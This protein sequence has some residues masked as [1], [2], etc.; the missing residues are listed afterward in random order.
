[1]T[2]PTY[3]RLFVKMVRD[4]TRAHLSKDNKCYITGTTEDL[5][6]HHLYTLSAL[7]N[8]YLTK[9][10]IIVTADNKLDIREDF[11]REYSDKIQKQYVLTKKMHRKLHIIFGLKYPNHIV[12]KVERWIE[13][14]RDKY[15]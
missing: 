11:I 6:I 10:D 1:M 9:N 7:V 5:E 2:K 12:P 14:Q 13:L 4:K 15:K 3:D 8:D